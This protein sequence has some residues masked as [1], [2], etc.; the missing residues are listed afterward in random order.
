MKIVLEAASNAT[1]PGEIEVV[2][3]SLKRLGFV[4]A[5]QQLMDG[6]YLVEIADDLVPEFSQLDFFPG[7]SG[8]LRLSA[9][10]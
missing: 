1:E 3:L 4:Q 9:L 5:C 8:E 10:Q 7:C 2:L 6:A